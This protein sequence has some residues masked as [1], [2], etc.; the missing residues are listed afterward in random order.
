MKKTY[1]L[2]EQQYREI[3][4]QLYEAELQLRPI[5]LL[6]QQYPDITDEDAYA[7]QKAG[8]ELRLADG[9]KVVGRKIGLTSRGMM[10]QIGCDTPDYAYLTASSCVAEGGSIARASLNIPLVEGEMAF[11]MGEDLNKEHVSVADVMNATAWVVP[12]F[13]VC[14][15]RYPAWKGIT[16]R[17]TISDRAGAALF[18]IGSA[19][20]RLSEINPRGIGM[21]MEKNGDLLGSAAGVEVMGSPVTSVAWLANKLLEYGDWLKRGDIV[22][23]GAFMASDAA[24]AG[25]HY[26]VTLDG[27]PTLSVRFV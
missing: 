23:S 16:V 4:R 12:C 3:A 26:A 11:I 1:G 7:I 17:D 22:L 21:V 19:P 2:S 18:M 24:A 9:E 25:D 13:E 27:F 6:T 15:A 10:K 20:K 8:M 14:D 5:P